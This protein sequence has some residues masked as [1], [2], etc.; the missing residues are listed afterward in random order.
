LRPEDQRAGELLLPRVRAVKVKEFVLGGHNLPRAVLSAT[1]IENQL[2]EI[3]YHF[4]ALSS[5]M[6]RYLTSDMEVPRLGS[7][8]PSNNISLAQS[9]KPKNAQILA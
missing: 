5:V 4:P 8:G 9:K 1:L 2:F 7:G 3:E 6:W